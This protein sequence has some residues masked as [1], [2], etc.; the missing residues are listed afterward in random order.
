MV[1]WLAEVG[2]PVQARRAAAGGRDRQ[3]DHGGGVGRDRDASR[4]CG[5]AGA[6]AATGQVIATFDGR[7]GRRAGSRAVSDRRPDRPIRQ[8]PDRGR[9]DGRGCAADRV[10]PTSRSQAPKR[11]R[12]RSSRRNRGPDRE[13]RQ[14]RIRPTT[15]A[16]SSWASTADGLDPRVRGRGEV[17]VPGGGDARHDPPVPGSGGD[18]RGRCAALEAGDFITSTFRGHGHALA[19]GLT[20]EE[21]LFELFGATTGCCRGKGG[22]MHV[23]NMD[24]GMVPGI[25]IVAGGVPLAAGMALCVQDAEEPG[26]RRLLL[27]RR[28]GG[29]GGVSRG[30]QP[31]RHLGPARHVRLREQPLRRVD[32]GRSRDAEPADRRS[33]AAYGIRGERVDGND[34]LA[35][36]EAARAAAADC[37]A[38]RGPVLLELL[39]Y[40]RTGH[41]RRDACHYQPK[42]E[43]EEW[44]ARDP[45]DR[46]GRHLIDRGLAA[47]TE[48]EEVRTEDSAPIPGRRRAGSAAADAFARRPDDGRLRLTW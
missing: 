36:Y 30:R 4:D 44:F 14:Q 42:E 25:A 17:P 2:Q 48:L 28:G 3:V 37:R 31:R 18:G 15:L 7:R 33:G 41:S 40:R 34:V 23:G 46:L 10:G 35:V 26:D 45:I 21:L 5:P 22:S 13:H 1:G 47:Q 9:G 20:P 43:R 32:P 19:K 12:A 8:R 38:G 29:R 39:T 16:S 6:E 11:G 24:K 27:R